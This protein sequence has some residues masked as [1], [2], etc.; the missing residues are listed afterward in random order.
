MLED[1]VEHIH[2]I[3]ARIESRTSRM[4]NKALQPFLHSKIEAIQNS[5][6]MKQ[7]IQSSK[8]NAKR[9]F[10]KR[11][12]EANS[13][14]RNKKLKAERDQMRVEILE[15]IETKTH[16]QLDPIKFKYK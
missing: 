13:F 16:L 6:V 12:P 7:Q 10:K 2:Q 11:N 5:Q 9:V 1:D 14:I 4:T 15:K 8:D 3:A